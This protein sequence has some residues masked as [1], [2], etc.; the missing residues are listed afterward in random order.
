MA[1]LASILSPLHLIL[2]NYPLL[3][4]ARLVVRWGAS[5]A[6]DMVLTYGGDLTWK[7]A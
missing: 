5:I 6:F 7:G 1:S 2:W 4:K 3:P